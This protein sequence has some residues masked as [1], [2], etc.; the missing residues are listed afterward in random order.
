MA[1]RYA[2]VLNLDAEAELTRPLGYNPTAR[3]RSSVALFRPRVTGLLQEH[4]AILPD[5]PLPRPLFKGYQG[6]AWCPTP[7]AL[8]LLTR[9]GATVPEA[10]TL[11][12]LQNV[13]SRRF[14]ASLG[15]HLSGATYVTEL[16]AALALVERFRAT[17]GCVLKREYGFTGRGQRRI[18]TDP[19]ADD[20][21]WILQALKLGGLQIEPKLELEAEYALHGFISRAHGVHFGV[22]TG[23]RTDK[24]GSWVE[25]YRVPPAEL[26]RDIERELQS[27]TE[28]VC[29]ALQAADYFGPFGIDG[30]VYRDSH[31]MRQLNPKSDVNARY[32]MGFPVGMQHALES[33]AANEWG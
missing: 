26:D 27:S 10:P 22:L 24:Q 33:G 15:Q 32:T 8:R 31:G 1:A 16:D 4:D 28:R 11:A 13:C 14:N 29:A 6:R 17:G 18:T 5:D 9:S 19:I 2:W 23:Q 3:T 30:F 20:H 7:R 12:C 21:K 25:S